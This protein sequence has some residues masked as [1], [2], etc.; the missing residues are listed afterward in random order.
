M[1]SNVMLLLATAFNYG[2]YS[3]ESPVRVPKI[4]SNRLVAAY[5]FVCVQMWI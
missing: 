5:F 3:D 1:R 2:A 4:S